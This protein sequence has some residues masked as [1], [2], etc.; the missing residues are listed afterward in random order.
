MES[1]Y[2]KFNMESQEIDTGK[3]ELVIVIQLQGSFIGDKTTAFKDSCYDHIER[4]P[5]TIGVD[6]FEVDDFDSSA[7]A[8]LIS[9]FTYSKTKK[10][11]M[12][13][14]N[15][16]YVVEKVLD[17]TFQGKRLN[18]F[19]STMTRDEFEKVINA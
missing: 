7:L 18:K 13:L 1:E 15:L 6:C 8:A 3:Q 19:F 11:K 10:I 2:S 4:K 5:A 17:G 14:F 16:S 9:I 12:I